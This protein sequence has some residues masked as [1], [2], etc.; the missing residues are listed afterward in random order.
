MGRPEGHAP[1]EHFVKHHAEAVDVGAAVDA[2]GRARGL[3][4]RHV[5]RRAGDDAFGAG[6]ACAATG[7]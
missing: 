7:Q 1:G 3:L 6:A 5:P 2:V 4:R